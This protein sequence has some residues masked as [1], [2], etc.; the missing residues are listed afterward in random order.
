MG[1]WFKI[2]LTL[3]LSQPGLGGV[4]AGAELGNKK[5]VFKEN[6]NVNSII[7]FGGRVDSPPHQ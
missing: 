3:R 4:G 2:G 5:H 7:G 1:G 6:N